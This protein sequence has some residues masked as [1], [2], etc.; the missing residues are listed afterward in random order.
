MSKKKSRLVL[1]GIILAS[2]LFSLVLQFV[3][4]GENGFPIAITFW[5]MAMVVI[6]GFFTFRDG[7]KTVEKIQKANLLLTEEHDLDAYIAALSELV[8]TEDSLQAQQILRIN[9]TVAYCGKHDYENALRVL[10]EIKDP[11][12]LN[13][14]NAAFYWINMALCSFYLGNDEEGMRIVKLQKA[15]FDQMRQAQQTGPALAFLE[16]FE[17]FHQGSTED[18]AALFETARAAWENEENAPEFALV[19]EKCGFELLPLPGQAEEREEE[20]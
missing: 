13:K 19:A 2:C 12:R 11:K 10:Q 3:D 7:R 1:G 15:A 4:L 5:M 9:L 20:E 6:Y 14:P 8:K 18:A 17:T 16:V